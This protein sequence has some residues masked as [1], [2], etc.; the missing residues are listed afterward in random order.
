MIKIRFI[1]DVGILS[2]V[3]SLI[4]STACFLA[5]TDR[6]DVRDVRAQLAFFSSLSIPNQKPGWKP[7]YIAPF[8]CIAQGLKPL[9]TSIS[10][11]AH[12]GN[13]KI[14]IV[15]GVYSLFQ[16]VYGRIFIEIYQ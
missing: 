1:F 11:S 7:E 12:I 13:Q 15:P 8:G 6:G 5:P 9:L 3:I 14:P 4:F 16:R 10:P 2:L